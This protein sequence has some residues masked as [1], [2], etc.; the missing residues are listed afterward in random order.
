MA[1]NFK[2]LSVMVV[3]DT[4]PMRKLIRTLLETFD[5]GTVYTATNGENGFE[6]FC[7]NNPDIVLADWEMDPVN[8]IG[9]TQ[10]IRTDSRSPNR[11][12]PIILVTGYNALPRVALARDAGVTEF[13]IK[14]FT[15][16][17]LAKRLAYVINKPRDFID[18]PRYFGPDRRRRRNESYAGPLRRN[19]DKKKQQA[20]G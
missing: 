3:E 7:K 13:M 17:D 11:L 4:G 19:E 5:V 20:Q 14:P 6:S 16:N 15:A 18:A 9:L 8:G 1:L 10:K 2:N 12:A